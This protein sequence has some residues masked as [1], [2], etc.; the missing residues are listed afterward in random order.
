VR[1][2]DPDAL[3]R[4]VGPR[5]AQTLLAHYRSDADGNP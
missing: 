2:A 3:K 5:A 1:R 4:A